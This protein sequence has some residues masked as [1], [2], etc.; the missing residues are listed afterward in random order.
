[1]KRSALVVTAVLAAACSS[2]ANEAPVVTTPAVPTSTIAYRAPTAPTTLSYI[3]AD[4]TNSNI[5]AGPA[6]TINVNITAR[7]TADLRFEPMGSDQKVT[8]TL[9]DFLGQFSNS[10]GGG[11]M[12]ATHADLKGPI[13]FTVDARGVANITTRPEL[14][15]TFRTVVGSEN[16]FKRFF[17]RV[18]AGAVPIGAVW[19]D[20]TTSEET[21]EG[22]TS[23][24]RNIVRSTYARDTIIAGRTL[25][26]LTGEG[27]RWLEVAGISQGVEIVQ[28]LT[29]KVASTVLWDAARA[30][31]IL[32]DESATL[33]GTFDLPAMNLTGMP[34]SAT[35]RTIIQLKTN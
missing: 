35:G 3:F 14:T 5:Q 13:V 4:T 27:E 20:T 33:S 26:V 6:G 29:G 12:S 9:T 1:M 18:P 16:N 24:L 2:A 23:K 7:G 10:A 30:A 28:R 22:I 32:K 34:I 15:S 11:T 25:H 17:T 31:V 8:L 21:N 19:T